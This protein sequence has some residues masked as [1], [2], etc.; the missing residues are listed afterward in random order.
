MKDL[1]DI[2]KDI[3]VK[4]ILLLTDTKNNKGLLPIIQDLDYWKKGGYIF[5][6]HETDAAI[7]LVKVDCK[8]EN[9]CAYSLEC[10][11]N[12]RLIN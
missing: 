5:T 6:A 4:Q 10:I 12:T 2:N 3:K 9:H 8:T 11:I 7:T 1:I